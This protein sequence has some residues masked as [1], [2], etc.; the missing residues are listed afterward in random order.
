MDGS[1]PYE[2]T[3]PQCKIYQS[4]DEEMANA[5]SCY[6][7]RA[8]DD[9]VCPQANATKS[10]ASYP[11]PGKAMSVVFKCNYMPPSGK[12]P[13]DC[14]DDKSLTEYLRKA[15]VSESSISDW[16]KVCVAFCGASKAYYVDR[17]LTKPKAQCVNDM[18]YDSGSEGAAGAV[19]K[20]FCEE[21]RKG[22]VD[23]TSSNYRKT[24]EVC[25]STT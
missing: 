16:L 21:L 12:M 5:D 13:V 15:G 4:R 10:M 24:A 3:E 7:I 25:K 14:T 6:N 19:N 2:P 8:L 9:L 22:G 1:E 23:L 11:I 20:D 17:T 18:T